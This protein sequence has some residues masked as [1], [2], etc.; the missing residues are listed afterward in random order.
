MVRPLSFALLFLVEERQAV[1]TQN[2][3]SLH[4]TLFARRQRPELGRQ[5]TILIVEPFVCDEG[6][7][8]WLKPRQHPEW[9]DG[10]GGATRRT[11]KLT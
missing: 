4:L 7:D 8:S 10:H 9:M 11:W 2:A 6:R 1:R 5:H 3:E